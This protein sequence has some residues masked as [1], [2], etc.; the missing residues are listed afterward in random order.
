[1]TRRRY[2][3]PRLTVVRFAAER[4]Y[5]MSLGVIDPEQV[6]RDLLIGMMQEDDYQTAETFNVYWTDSEDNGFFN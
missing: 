5:A 6:E 1:M 2:Q 4:G 3:P